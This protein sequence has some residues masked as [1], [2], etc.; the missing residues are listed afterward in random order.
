MKQQVNKIEE[1]K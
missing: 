1:I